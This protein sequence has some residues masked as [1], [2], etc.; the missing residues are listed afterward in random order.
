MRVAGLAAHQ[1][2]AHRALVADP[3]RRVAARRLAGGQS[4]RSGRWLSRVWIDRPALSPEQREQR[5]DGR[6]DRL[7]ARHVVAERG[8]EA[9]GSMKSRCMS[10][11]TSAVRP[12]GERT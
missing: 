11:T 3:Q 10:M 8:A 9:A 1:D 2:A 5:R 12:G 6:H 7:Q 4:D